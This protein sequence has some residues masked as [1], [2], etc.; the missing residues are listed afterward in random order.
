MAVR[1]SPDDGA[2]W[3]HKLMV[4]EGS[5]AYSDIVDLGDGRVGVLFERD[6]YGSVTFSPIPLSAFPPTVTPTPDMWIAK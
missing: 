6:G 2:T 4:Y 5:A 3:P 1:L